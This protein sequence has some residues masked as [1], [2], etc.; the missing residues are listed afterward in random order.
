MM[1]I[2]TAALAS[3]VLVQQAPQGIEQTSPGTRPPPSLVESFDGMGVG[4]EGPQG[5]YEGRNPSDNSLAV[6][7]DHIVQT[8][9]SRLRSSKKGKRFRPAAGR[10]MVSHT[11]LVFAGLGGPCE[12]RNNGDAV[13]RYDQLANRWL[14]TMPI[15]SRIPLTEVGE[16]PPIGTPP[17]PGH[18]AAPG[19]ASSPGPAPALPANPPM[20][21]PPAPPQGR[22]RGQPAAGPP[23]PPPPPSTYGMC[24]AI[25]TTP[26]PLGPYF[27]YAFERPLFPD[28]PRPAVWIA[29]YYVPTSSAKTESPNGRDAEARVRRRSRDEGRGRESVPD[30]S[31]RELPEQRRHRRQCPPPSGA[32]RQMAAGGTQPTSSRP[33]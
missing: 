33:T 17:P 13:V 21:P 29:G 2:V 15:F 8:V 16:R 9:N 28:Y 26:D 24:Y 12:A 7:P 22:G 1:R 19:Q 4:F 3:L 18:L 14:I 6:G 27:R 10:S 5:K 25:S 23:P 20:H 31:E 32:P 11:N 30:R